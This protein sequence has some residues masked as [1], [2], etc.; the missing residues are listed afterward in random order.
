MRTYS[1]KHSND[2]LCVIEGANFIITSAVDDG[3]RLQTNAFHCNLRC[4]QE[5]VIKVIEELVPVLNQ[6][7]VLSFATNNNDDNICIAP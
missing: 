4:Q 2:V 1:F 3:H 6:S 7:T 5:P